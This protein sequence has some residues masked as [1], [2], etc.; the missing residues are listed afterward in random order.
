MYT[1]IDDELYA[2]EDNSLKT[3]SE[4]MLD[5]CTKC[6]TFTQMREYLDEA[7]KTRLK[8]DCEKV[9][10]EWNIYLFSEY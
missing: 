10:F 6:K 5:L 7:Y 8:K 1:Y 3:I 4:P 2:V 9:A